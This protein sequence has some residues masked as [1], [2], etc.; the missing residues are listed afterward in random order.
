MGSTSSKSTVLDVEAIF[1]SAFISYP[2]AFESVI[3]VPIM[4][5]TAEIIFLFSAVIVFH[6]SS[7]DIGTIGIL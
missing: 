4:S 7:S 3:T 1:L 6:N 2:F 5:H